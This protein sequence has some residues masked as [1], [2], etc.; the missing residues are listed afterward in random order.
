MTAKQ[1]TYEALKSRRWTPGND[2]EAF[3]GDLRRLRELR[4]E[5]MEIKTR[6]TEDGYEYRLVRSNGVVA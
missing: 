5:G 6:R 4:A 2:I 3:G 1:A